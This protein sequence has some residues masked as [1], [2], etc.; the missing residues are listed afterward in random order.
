MRYILIVVATL[1]Q[2]E[3]RWPAIGTPDYEFKKI[4][5]VPVKKTAVFNKRLLYF[6]APWCGPCIQFQEPEFKRMQAGPNPWSI[7]KPSVADHIWKYD[8]DDPTVKELKTQYNIDLVPTFV[9][10]DADGR[11]LA[12]SVGTMTSHQILALYNTKP[13]PRKRK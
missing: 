1:C 10:V 5:Q 6:S 12:R 3:Y 13:S 7:G 9:L 11:E 4:V 2:F 8:V